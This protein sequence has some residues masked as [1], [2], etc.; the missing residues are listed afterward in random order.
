MLS[1]KKK[2]GA[3]H[4]CD[5]VRGRSRPTPVYYYHDIDDS[6][7][8]EVDSMQG[9]L[10]GHRGDLKEYL[11]VNSETLDAAI[12]LLQADKEPSDEKPGIRRAYWHL[13][14][15][16]RSLIRESMDLRDVKGKAHFEVN[17]AREKDDWSFGTAFVAGSSGS[18]KTWW[19]CDLVLRHWK[20]A[21]PHNRR[22]VYYLSPELHD[23]KS[24]RRISDVK[25]YEDWFHGIDVS[26]DRFEAAQESRDTFFQKNVVDQLAHQRN[27][28]IICDD[29]QDSGI[30]SLLRKYTDRLL[31][32]GRHKGISTITLQHNLRNS[33]FSRQSV[34]SCKHI[35]LFPRAQRG[36]VMNF[37]K[38]TVGLSLKQAKELTNLMSGCS[39]ACVIR[40]H[41]P[42]MLISGSY[43]K[44]L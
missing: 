10:Q 43:I 12:A 19:V 25:K 8:M 21:T 20:S 22:H 39:R 18:G 32:T 41:A 17:Y 37:L 29:F 26:I 31:R 34:A 9:L 4:V 15:F 14:K 27:A 38:D 44:L 2:D 11:K 36:K 16:T 30:P 35:V 13:K 23:D 33:S 7:L 24:L 5:I 40:M 3:V 6:L 28:I 42:M 1:L